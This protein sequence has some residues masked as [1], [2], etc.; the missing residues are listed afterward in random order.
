MKALKNLIARLIL[1]FR[2]KRYKG[3]QISLPDGFKM[4]RS[5]MVCLPPDQKELTMIKQFLPDLSTVFA[6]AEIYLLASPGRN[7]YDIFPR[8]GYRIMCPSREQVSWS[9]LAKKK[10]VDRLKENNFDLIMDFNLHTNYFMQ[11]LLLSFPDAIKVGKGNWLGPPYYNLEVKTK[12]IR[13]E[14][15]IY[16]SIIETIGK[17]RNPESRKNDRTLN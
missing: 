16:K 14:R 12:F 17:L 15:N 9:G 5:V 7:I 10:Y 4:I 13:D 2:K 6:D 1:T 3:G 11:S 8:K